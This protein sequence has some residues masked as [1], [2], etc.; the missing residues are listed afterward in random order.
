MLDGILGKF[1]GHKFIDHTS[2]ALWYIR[3]MKKISKMADNVKQNE[4]VLPIPQTEEL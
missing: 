2:V 1:R 4:V 3:Y